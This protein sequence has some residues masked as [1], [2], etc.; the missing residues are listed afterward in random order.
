MGRSAWIWAVIR[1]PGARS[2]GTSVSCWAG[3]T[4]CGG[5]AG[6]AEPG[7]GGWRRRAGSCLVTRA[8][9]SLG[10]GS[11]EFDEQPAGFFLP[12]GDFLPD[13]GLFGEMARISSAFW[14]LSAVPAGGRWVRAARVAARTVGFALQGG[15]F[16]TSRQRPLLRCGRANH[17]AGGKGAVLRGRTSSHQAGAFGR[18]SRFR[19]RRNRFLPATAPLRPG[20]P[21]GS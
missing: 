10:S 11:A 8:A 7:A 12:F 20:S 9:G 5:A 19:P 17:R 6:Q 2:L 3:A 14:R 21:P 18:L 15:H 13:A 16:V 4:G 1:W